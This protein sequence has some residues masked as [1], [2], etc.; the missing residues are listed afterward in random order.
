MP[1]DF[2]F[3]DLEGKTHRLSEYRGRVVLLD[4]WMINCGWCRVGIPR[5]VDAYRRL[6]DM[7][8]EIIG[9][10]GEDAEGLL[11][12]FLAQNNMTWPQTIQDKDDGPI[13]KLY[14]VGS[15]P[16]YYLI[17]KDGKLASRRLDGG[18]EDEILEWAERL[19]R[20]ML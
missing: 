9:I 6:H 7:G 2:T 11:R 5:M 15:F 4:F 19:T 17:G 20:A 12:A 3:Q 14:K 13:H 18:A 10:N 8:L 16:A 1:P